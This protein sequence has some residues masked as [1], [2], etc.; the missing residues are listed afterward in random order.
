MK[1]EIRQIDAW[2]EPDG[3]WTYNDSIPV[4]YL[5][6]EGEPTTRRIL[7]AMYDKEILLAK[8][9]FKVDDYFS[10][11]G[12]WSIQR[13]DND[14]PVFDLHLIKP[15]EYVTGNIV[16]DNYPIFCQQVNCKGV[17]GAGLAKQIRDKYPEVYEEYR[18]EYRV[19]YSEL[20]TILPVV[21]HDG[22]VCINMYAQKEYG[23]DK[24]Y[25]NYAAFRQCLENLN[26]F[27]Q[28]H[29]VHEDVDIAFPYN[30]GCGLAGGDWKIIEQ[31]ITE[32]AEKSGLKAKIVVLK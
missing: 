7:K 9:T 20:G 24:R 10:Y 25:T 12:V 6:I 3:S 4:G 28:E 29:Y 14:M 11:D 13:R 26:R 31:L 22:R 32:F 23:T 18:E 15:V 21:T 2:R 8:R 5:E 27:L 17:M 16:E 30:I 19:G 1:F